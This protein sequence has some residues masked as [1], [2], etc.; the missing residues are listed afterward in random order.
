MRL[1]I[2]VGLLFCINLSQVSCNDND[3]EVNIDKNDPKIKD[4]LTENDLKQT[5]SF[6]CG[7]FF[8]GKNFKDKPFNKLFIIPKRFGI[9][10]TFHNEDQDDALAETTLPP[11]YSPTASCPMAEP[12]GTAE[13]PSVHND[14]CFWLFKKIVDK[15]KLEHSSF[16]KTPGKSIGDDTCQQVVDLKIKRMPP[17]K[18][19]EFGIPIGF[20]FNVCDDPTWY[21]TGLRLSQN[22]CCD[23]DKGKKD[24][25]YM[26]CDKF[27]EDG[28]QLKPCEDNEIA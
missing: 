27:C 13:N 12:Y 1:I 28:G 18:R 7:V 16:D 11:R 19:F 24:P 17:N 8:A 15:L 3:E 26:S 4:L 20:Y 22:L 9:N 6:R 10:A 2:F 21:D 25:T 23:L 14:T 5:E